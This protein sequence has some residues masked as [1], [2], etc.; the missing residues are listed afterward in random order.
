R[1]TLNSPSWLDSRGGARRHPHPSIDVPRAGR[2]A[3]ARLSTSADNS[4]GL[5]HTNSSPTNPGW[6]I[7]FAFGSVDSR[8][9]RATSRT[10]CGR[11]AGPGRPWRLSSHAGERSPGPTHENSQWQ[12]PTHAIPTMPLARVMTAGAVAHCAPHDRD[13]AF[14]PSCVLAAR[15]LSNWSLARLARTD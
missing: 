14:R 5:T 3:P 6:F 1:S 11:D 8:V 13:A 7:A 12:D 15:V 4:S 2:R 10:A 9:D